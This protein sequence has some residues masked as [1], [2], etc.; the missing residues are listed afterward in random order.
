MAKKL[1]VFVWDKVLCDATCGIIVVVAKDV[2]EA[3]KLAI[4][5]GN[6]YRSVIDAVSHEP[7]VVEIEKAFVVWGGG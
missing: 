3:R 7:E 6:E 5:E 4:K 2:E 1:K